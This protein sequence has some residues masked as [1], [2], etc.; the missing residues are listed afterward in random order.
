MKIILE[1]TLDEYSKQYKYDEIQYETLKYFEDEGVNIDLVADPSFNER[2]M[3]AILDGVKKGYNMQPL[4]NHQWGWQQI[5]EIVNAWNRKVDI[6]KYID[7]TWDSYQIHEIVLGLLHGID[8]TKYVDN[9]MNY[10]RIQQVRKA[11]EQ[12]RDVNLVL[13]HGEESYKKLYD[14]RLKH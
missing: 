14:R 5:E 9:T 2:E 7:S 13:K 6:L 10:R 12:D 8:L 1:K 3:L 11:L 4:A